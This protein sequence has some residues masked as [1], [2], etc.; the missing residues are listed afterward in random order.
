MRSMMEGMDKLAIEVLD[1]HKLPN[2]FSYRRAF[3]LGYNEKEK[4]SIVIVSLPKNPN[5]ESWINIHLGSG[6]IE[7]IYGKA[8]IRPSYSGDRWYVEVH[9]NDTMIAAMFA[10][11]IRNGG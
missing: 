8:T 10:N 9:Y 7:S 2:Q 5:K 4:N 6:I 1:K 3:E 11:A